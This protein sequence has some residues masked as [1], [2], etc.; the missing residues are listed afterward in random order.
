MTVKI[1]DRQAKSRLG[2]AISGLKKNEFG[3]SKPKWL[4][5]L[6]TIL[7]PHESQSS[8]PA[9]ACQS[10]ILLPNLQNH[11]L[12]PQSEKKRKL[13]IQL[14]LPRGKKLARAS[15][16][17]CSQDTTSCWQY[18]SF[19][20]LRLHLLVRLHAPYFVRLRAN[21]QQQLHYRNPRHTAQLPHRNLANFGW[22]TFLPSGCISSI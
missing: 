13:Q 1:R 22:Q 6:T 16:F 4:N 15:W 3:F 18:S 17:W 9:L 7:I 5:I 8:Q 19:I 20:H 14:L 2:A 10:R 12:E 21:G 11:E